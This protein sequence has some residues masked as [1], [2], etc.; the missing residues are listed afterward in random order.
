MLRLRVWLILL[1]ADVRGKALREWFARA[2]LRGRGSRWAWVGLTVIGV[3]LL[4]AQGWASLYL[5]HWNV[6]GILPEWKEE[7]WADLESCFWLDDDLDLRA[8]AAHVYLAWFGG[9]IATTCLE[10]LV[11]RWAFLWFRVRRLLSTR[12]RCFKC[13]YTVAGLGVME[14]ATAADRPGA[15]D[16]IDAWL[17]CTECGSETPAVALWGE[18]A[19]R[20]GAAEPAA[21]RSNTPALGPTEVPVVDTPKSQ[22]YFRPSTPNQSRVIRVLWTRNRI[23]AVARVTAVAAGLALLGYA[24]WWTVREVGIRSQ[25]AIALK[26]RPAAESINAMMREG[27]P[28][29][30]D[31]RR[32]VAEIIA[33]AKKEYDA[34]N[35]DFLARHKDV[36][37]EYD[38]FYPDASVISSARE[39]LKTDGDRANKQYSL[40][41]MEEV[42]A[43]NVYRLLDE[44]PEAAAVTDHEFRPIDSTAPYSASWMGNSR[45]VLR[46]CIA[47]MKIARDASDLA[48]FQR[49]A[50]SARAIGG[51]FSDHGPLL[52]WL[53]AISINQTLLRELSAAVTPEVDRAWVE[54]VAIESANLSAPSFAESLRYERL[55]IM[56]AIG[57]Y[58]SDPARVRSGL[59]APELKD[60]LGVGAVE[61]S[62]LGLAEPDEPGGPRP[63]LGT[64]EENRDA[65]DR[66]F[67]WYVGAAAV[68]PFER[69]KPTFPTQPQSNG[70]VIPESLSGVLG[71]ALRG[72]THAAIPR[73]G[74]ELMLMIERH[75]LDRG[76]YPEKLED[77]GPRALAPALFD[78]FSGQPMRYKRIDPAIDEFHR[79]YLLWSVGYDAVDDGG[80]MHPVTQYSAVTKSGEGTDII[81]NDPHGLW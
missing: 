25:A 13:G 20:G 30:V 26:E 34:I 74:L 9:A 53:V 54:A 18:I 11:L 68:D 12:D 45:S 72:R 27:M 58:F 5:A 60:K 24:G 66:Q 79:G 4:A 44:L 52:N 62:I 65:L 80:K 77:I 48:D 14:S 1:G 37:D 36:D 64:Y 67:E 78:P 75:R 32:T 15:D 21:S 40:L 7:V 41:L 46:I 31:G 2:A 22:R 61:L 33:Q 38:A 50:R 23:R 73:R 49:A 55:W 69:R 10:L 51:Q 76:T 19:E 47:R 59:R 71:M 35:T 39:E 63:R 57:W 8:R 3:C 16:G 29:Q 56:D 43:S 17:T 6:W 81:I 70:L 28:A 42:R